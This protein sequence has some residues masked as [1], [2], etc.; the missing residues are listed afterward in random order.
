MTQPQHVLKCSILKSTLSALFTTCP[1][2]KNDFCIKYLAC[3][4]CLLITQYAYKFSHYCNCVT[5]E[6]N[7]FCVCIVFFNFGCLLTIYR[8]G[9]LVDVHFKLIWVDLGLY[10]SYVICYATS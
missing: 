7:F 10:N 5:V 3:G 8:T 2:T 1:M 9:T 4:I 6:E